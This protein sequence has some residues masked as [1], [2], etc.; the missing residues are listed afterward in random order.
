MKK[1]KLKRVKDRYEEEEGDCFI[2]SLLIICHNTTTVEW[3]E[4]GD[5][6]SW[7]STSGDKSVDEDEGQVYVRGGGHD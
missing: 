2:D 6:T 3:S 7:L 1:P 5:V 4:T